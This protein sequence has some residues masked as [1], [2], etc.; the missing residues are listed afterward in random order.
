MLL[1]HCRQSPTHACLLPVSVLLS[2]GCHARYQ[3]M[4]QFAADTTLHLVLDGGQLS[5]CSLASLTACRRQCHVWHA[6]MELSL[7]EGMAHICCAGAAERMDNVMHQPHSLLPL[8][9]LGLGSQYW[10]QNFTCSACGGR[11]HCHGEGLPAQV[12]THRPRWLKQQQV[13]GSGISRM[14]YALRNSSMHFETD[15]E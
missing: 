2:T 5:P 12:V 14:Y 1:G 13:H 6:S 15:M 11:S 10:Q 9:S 7:T 8:S 4:F 3:C